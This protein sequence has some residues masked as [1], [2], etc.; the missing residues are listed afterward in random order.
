MSSNPEGPYDC[1][2]DD[3]WDPTKPNSDFSPS[4]GMEVCNWLQ[5][6][7]DDGIVYL[8][9]TTIRWGR[10]SCTIILYGLIGCNFSW[11]FHE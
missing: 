10:E 3:E 4:V 11:S 6:P 7:I 8:L 9:G 1:S 5:I 2:D